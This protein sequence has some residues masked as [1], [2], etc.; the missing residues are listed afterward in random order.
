MTRN[1][2][3]Q[4]LEAGEVGREID[5]AVGYLFPE[6]YTG[7]YGEPMISLDVGRV[8]T[9]LDAAVALCERV[10]PGVWR[11]MRGPRSTLSEHTLETMTSEWR[12]VFQFKGRPYTAVG[13]APTLAAALLAALLK[14]T[15]SGQ[16]GE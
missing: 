12:V 11:E 10:R 15:D 4:R 9:S 5:A 8:S 14:A 2:L 3:I 6:S 1:E 16:G 7:D 13:D